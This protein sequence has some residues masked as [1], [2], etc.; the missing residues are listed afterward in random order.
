M[1]SDIRTG[2]DSTID[3]R[4]LKFV[5]ENLAALQG[6]D[7]VAL[8]AMLLFLELRDVLKDPWWLYALNLAAVVVIVRQMPSKYYERHFGRVEPKT[9]SPISRREAVGGFVRILLMI[10]ALIWGRRIEVW[11]DAVLMGDQGGQIRWLA[12]LMWS[13]GLLRKTK[14]DS[15]ADPRG[16]LFYVFGLATS[17]AVCFYPKWY[18]EVMRSLIWKTLNAGSLGLTLIAWGLR[19]HLLLVHL[20]PKKGSDDEDE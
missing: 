15:S 14:K 7:T 3:H 1:D 5:T 2:D 13:V 10:V 12:S 20:L 6:L 18:P 9:K 4:R 11:A 19:D 16:P 8:G 17:I